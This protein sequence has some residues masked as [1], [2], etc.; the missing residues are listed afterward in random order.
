LQILFNSKQCDDNQDGHL[1]FNTAT[2]ESRFTKTNQP[3][4]TITYFDALNNP[5]LDANGALITSRFIASFATN[6]Q[7]IRQSNNTSLSFCDEINRI[8]C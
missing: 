5:L 3:A 7:T 6:S 1:H 2:L 8:H 4:V